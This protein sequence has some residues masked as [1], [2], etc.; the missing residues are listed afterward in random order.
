MGPIFWEISQEMKVLQEMGE[1][2]SHEDN[3]PW[4][5]LDKR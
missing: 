1:L 5:N 2:T 3:Q 4:D